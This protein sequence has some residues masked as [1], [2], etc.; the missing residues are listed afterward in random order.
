MNNRTTIAAVS[1]LV[2]ACTSGLAVAQETASVEEAISPFSGSFTLAT[3]Y[4]FRGI[5]Q[6]QGDPAVQGNIEYTRAFG[7]SGLSAYA[8]AFG[9]NVDFAGTDARIELDWYGGLRGSTS[10][11]KWDAGVVYYSYPGAEDSLDLDYG[12]AVLKVEYDFTLA[13]AL[14]A[15]AYSPDFQ[16]GAGSGFYI[17]GGADV[18]LPFE[19][20]LFARIGRQWVDDNQRWALP[21]YTDWSLALARDLYGLTV[22]VGYYDTNIGKSNCGG[23]D[24]CDA[25]IMVG[26][27]KKL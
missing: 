22:S 20:L 19:F 5:S 14:A 13:K 18:A 1:F 23:S 27:T 3:D 10:G 4:V 15:V 11:I 12:E 6:T 21:D 8:G 24:N 16:T 17:N 9:S 26:V 7:E 25:R 2:A